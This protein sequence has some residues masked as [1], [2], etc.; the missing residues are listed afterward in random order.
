LLGN[1]HET[2]W[3]CPML[4]TQEPSFRL[5]G[6][7]GVWF[8]LIG[9][10]HAQSTGSATT[11]SAGVSVGQVRIGERLDDVHRALGTPK[12]S[13]A[14]MGGKLLEVWRSGPGFEGRRQNGVEELE[15]YFRREGPDFSGEPVVR[16]IRATSPFFRTVSGISVRSSFAQISS[17]FPNLSDDEELTYAING[18]RSEKEIEAFVDRARGIA[19]EFRNGAAADPDARGYCRA[20]HIFQ[21]NTDPRPIQNFARESED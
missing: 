18:G 19:F 17:E 2:G 14:A 1:S 5:L 15:I 9:G 8:L 6:W 7:L 4:I 3:I 11:I 10:G 16:Q 21:P 20:I 13:D 12:L